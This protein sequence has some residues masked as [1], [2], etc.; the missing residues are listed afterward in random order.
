MKTTNNWLILLISVDVLLTMIVPV[1]NVSRNNQ[2]GIH[3]V[4]VSLV[5]YQFVLIVAITVCVGRGMMM[6][7]MSRIVDLFKRLV[8][9]S[10]RFPVKAIN[11]SIGLNMCFCCSNNLGRNHQE[12]R[13]IDQASFYRR[14]RIIRQRSFA[15]P[16]YPYL[17]LSYQPLFSILIHQNN[18]CSV[19]FLK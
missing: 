9:V 10:L 1:M 16:I 13:Q 7:S 3:N 11:I 19:S 15:I 6:T 4:V 8:I 5:G 2:L 17:D 18:L 14:A 12:F